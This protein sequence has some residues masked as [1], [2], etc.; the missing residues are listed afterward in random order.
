VIDLQCNGAGGIDLTSEPERL[1]EVA[2]LLP[3]WGVTQWLPT[4]CSSPPD[5]IDRAL[6]TLRARPD[7]TGDVAEPLG[8]HLEGP[9]LNPDHRGAHPTRALSLPEDRAWSRE[10]GVAMVTL[11]PELPGALELTRALVDRG[12]VVSAG[13][14]GASLS[15]MDAAADA[16][17]TMVTHLFN[18]MVG[19]H[20]RAPGVVG[21]AL[22]DERLRV[23]VICDGVHVSPTV[24]ALA[25]RLLGE[26][27]VVVT[28]AVAT[29]GVVDDA[30][31][32][33]DG[34][35][36]GASVGM[37]GAVRNLAAF[38][39]CSDAEAMAAATTAPAAALG[40]QRP[41]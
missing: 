36:A 14:S 8:L 39:G 22:S 15:E 18:G 35:L 30:L 7:G 2:A 31:R 16:G 17:V 20:H 28:D 33:T 23:G 13:H 12:V 32:L 41:R 6:A 27:F 37:D 24:V 40:L 3:R 26:R 34:T 25:W 29:L 21:A 1:W 38:T 11:A 9:F 19:L 10:A 5:R 4:I